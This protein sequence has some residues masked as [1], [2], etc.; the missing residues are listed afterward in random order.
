MLAGSGVGGADRSV[1]VAGAAGVS[2]GFRHAAFRGTKGADAAWRATSRFARASGDARA[3]KQ[4]QGLLNTSGGASGGGL[5]SGKVE[6]REATH[7]PTSEYKALRSGD[8]AKMGRAATRRAITTVRGSG[9][10]RNR[11]TMARSKVPP[12]SVV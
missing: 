6:T 3:G 10:R 11:G 2:F 8:V 12:R 9:L 4:G 5:R 7:P 1:G